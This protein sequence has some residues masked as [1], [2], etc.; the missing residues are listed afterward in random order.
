MIMSNVLVYQPPAK[1]KKTQRRQKY[2]HPK[3]QSLA[4]RLLDEIERRG[5]MTTLQMRKLIWSWSYPDIPY[6]PKKGRSRWNTN[7][8]GTGPTGRRPGL[9][10]FFCKK[11]GGYRGKWVRNS[12]PHEDHPYLV[13]TRAN[14]AANAWK[15]NYAT[16]GQYIMTYNPPI[17]GGNP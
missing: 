1:R 11:D 15:V 16:G 2:N 5:G 14:K 12:V 10:H 8:Y 9:L 7:F 6:D 4:V 3:R 13:M 17:T